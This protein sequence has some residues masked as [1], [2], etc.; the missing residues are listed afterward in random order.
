MANLFP[1]DHFKDEWNANT[2]FE[3][4]AFNKRTE[5]FWTIAHADLS[6]I[7]EAD[8]IELLALAVYDPVCTVRNATLLFAVENN[9]FFTNEVWKGVFQ[10]KSEHPEF[11]IQFEV[12]CVEEAIEYKE[13]YTRQQFYQVL[14]GCDNPTLN[15]AASHLKNY[16]ILH[17]DAQ[18]SKATPALRQPSALNL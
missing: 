5:L 7:A 15:S 3:T 10:L 8:K 17:P 1:V 2:G 9:Q 6:D 11:D 16:M 13:R 12:E 18:P 4:A 14:C